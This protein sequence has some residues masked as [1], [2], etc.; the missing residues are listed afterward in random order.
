MN[1]DTLQHIASHLALGQVTERPIKLKSGF[2]NDVWRVD[3][4]T[5][6]YVVKCIHSHTARSQAEYQVAE[7]IAYKVQQAG[8][9]CV[10]A[11]SF[12]AKQL[13]EFNGQLLFIYPF[14]EGQCLPLA[15]ATPSQAKTIGT[16]LGK[17]HSLE[18]DVEEPFV[19]ARHAVSE[20]RWKTLQENAEQ[21]N[22]EVITHI[23]RDCDK[24]KSWNEKYCL[25]AQKLD[26]DLLASHRD[27]NQ[28]NVIWKEGEPFLIDW[29]W[30]GAIN[31]HF[32]AIH[33]A[34]VWAGLMKCKFDKETYH[35]FLSGYQQS[36]I[37][38]TDDKSLVLHA[39]RGLWL[40]WL[41]F[42][43]QAV[44]SA[45]ATQADVKLGLQEVENA[46]NILQF[47]DTKT[48]AMNY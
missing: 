24:L 47:I 15:A 25:A 44:L 23:L 7:R 38:L 33:S 28:G 20:S 18:L 26:R 42:S 27:L 22:N 6:R 17:I 13:L 16:L 5:S 8:I 14:I 39:I 31:P 45:H 10:P 40:D 11:N 41:A 12:N 35:A 36:G 32:E 29:E 19:N 9:P 48:F 3:T 21:Q 4:T 1:I 30:A 46:Y 43:M 34:L 37:K 2:L